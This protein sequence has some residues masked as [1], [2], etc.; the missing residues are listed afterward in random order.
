MMSGMWA[1]RQGIKVAGLGAQHCAACHL[2]ITGP[3]C[4]T[5]Y[6]SGTVCLCTSS[7]AFDGP[8]SKARELHKAFQV[9]TGAKGLAATGLPGMPPSLRY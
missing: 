8:V 4:C 9:S 6:L 5:A 2:C 3:V 1:L 7:T